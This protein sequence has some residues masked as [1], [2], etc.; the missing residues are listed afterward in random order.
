MNI[1]I[2][3]LPI[4]LLAFVALSCNTEYDNYDAPSVVFEGQLIDTEGDNFQFD[5]SKDLFVFYQS[6]YGKVDVGT[7]MSVTNDGAF[8][9]LLYKD[10]YTLTLANN[11][12]PFSIEEFPQNESGQGYD[13]I[14]YNITGTTNVNFTVLPYYKVSQVDA[15]YDS[16]TK[17]I[18]ATF[19]VKRLVSDAPSLKRAYLYLGTN[20][21]VNT[22]NKCQR[23]TTLKSTDADEQT[24]TVYIPIS[25]YRNKNYGMINNFRDY[26]FYRIGLMVTGY[27]DYYLF[28]E[29]KKIE[30]LTDLDTDE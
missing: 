16:I 26:A 8:R 13:S 12:Y 30:G 20:V 19:T 27:N 15:T 1:K 28:S 2:K 14:Q 29:T 3:Y 24:F 18:Y 6:G 10:H 9:Q 11:S 5:A 25:Y 21:N 23:M 4:A 7:G 17:R 22:S